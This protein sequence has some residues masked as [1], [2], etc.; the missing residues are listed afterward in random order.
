[1]NFLNKLLCKI[2]TR[3]NMHSSRSLSVLGRATI[4]NALNLSRLWH[5]AWV[6]LF[7]TSFLSK[8]RQVITRF[9]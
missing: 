1:N 6:T 5:L 4:A 3:I 7:P 2:K 9:V 8:V